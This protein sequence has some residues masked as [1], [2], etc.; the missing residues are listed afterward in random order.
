[1]QRRPWV[2]QVSLLRPGKARTYCG[3]LKTTRATATHCGSLPRFRRG[4]AMSASQ[5]IIQ[6][7]ILNIAIE[8]HPRLSDFVPFVES[9]SL[10][11]PEV[12]GAT[13]NNYAAAFLTLLDLG[14]VCAYPV[15]TEPGE[16]DQTKLDRSAVESILEQRLQ[17]PRVTSRTRLRANQQKPLS[18]PSTPDLRWRMTALGGDAW[19]RLAKPNWNRYGPTLTD[20][21][22]G[23]IW[24]ANRDLLMAELGWYRELTS[25]KVDRDSVRIEV[26]DSHPITYWKYLPL[27]YHAAFS[28]TPDADAS[29]LDWPKWFREWWLSQNQWYK[30]PWELPGWPPSDGQ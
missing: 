5:E 22:F 18:K 3:R 17:L 7:W 2:P 10:N 23:D 26:V 16:E 15:D 28:C 1:M 12:P 9:E 20:D 8:F 4:P 25:A 27:V 13:P 24:S 6:H 14:F 30:K 29:P 21:Y 19:E 11:V